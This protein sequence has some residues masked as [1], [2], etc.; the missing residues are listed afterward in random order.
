M[1]KC[2][3]SIFSDGVPMST[4][5][6]ADLFGKNLFTPDDLQALFR[7]FS[8]R[9]EFTVNVATFGG[10]AEPLIAVKLYEPGDE[11][12]TLADVLPF[13]PSATARRLRPSARS[14]PRSA[15]RRGPVEPV[16]L[17]KRSPGRAPT[18]RRPCSGAARSRFPACT[19][20]CN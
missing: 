11:A 9:S 15:L 6:L 16:P 3:V 5:S 2:E 17:P 20:A 4:T 1:S 14:A 7:A 10:G 8:D 18:S 13:K 19:T 12:K